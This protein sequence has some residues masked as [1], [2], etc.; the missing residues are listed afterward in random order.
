VQCEWRD[1]STRCRYPG[2]LTTNTGTGGPWYCSAHFGCRD[3]IM[4]A[5]IVAASADYVHPNP[6]EVSAEHQHRATDY[7]AGLGLKSVM[8]MREW[9]RSKFKGV[10]KEVT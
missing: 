1:G 6:G 4:G 3:P 2:A 5:D 8:E 7:C 10:Y 9:A